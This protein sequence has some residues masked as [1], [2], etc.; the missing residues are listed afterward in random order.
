MSNSGSELERWLAGGEFLASGQLTN[1][2]WEPGF[3]FDRQ[4]VI[5]RLGNFYQKV[6]LRPDVFTK[7]FYHEIYPLPIEEWTYQEQIDLF[8]GFCR[9]DIDVEL[10]FQ[11]TLTYVQRNI[12]VLPELSQHI[13]HSFQGLL[14]DTVHKEL[15]SLDDGRWVQKGLQELEKKIA[16]DICERLMVQNIQSQAICH[17]K[18]EF[19]D[20]PNVKPGKDSVYLYVL[21][22][23]HELTEQKN[24]TFFQQQQIL[25][26]QKLLH[27]RQELEHLQK[28][29]EVERQRR[30]QEAENRLILLQDEEHQLSA[31]LVVEKRMQAETIKHQQELKEMEMDAE[32]QTQQNYNVRQRQMER[33]NLSDKLEHQSIVEEKKLQADIS[34]REKQ[35]LHQSEIHD[36][37]TRAEIER[38]EKQQETWRQAKLRIHEQQLALKKRQKE[39]EYEAEQEY[40]RKQQETKKNQIVMPFQKLEKFEDAEKVKRKSEALRNEIELSLLEKQR[41]DLEMAIKEAQKNRASDNEPI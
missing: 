11:A 35:L 7:R 20:F 30:A 1:E 9:I 13:Q 6:F 17:L 29:A 8:D 32:L 21:K 28:F 16:I 39:L 31:R 37:K 36:S 33:Q 19:K 41:L 18:A 34:R 26:E 5:S 10:R 24:K 22:Q 12:E 2:T 38:Y 27:K 4:V 15:Q 40:K 23:N 3:D 14:T 25:K